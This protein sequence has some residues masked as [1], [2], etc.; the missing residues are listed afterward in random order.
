MG[1]SQITYEVSKLGE[2]WAASWSLQSWGMVRAACPARAYLVGLRPV[3]GPIF[4][5]KGPPD[6]GHH[7]LIENSAGVQMPGARGPSGRQGA[8]R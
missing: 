7:N 2:W 1:L 8:F 6:L 5:G 4:R 3:S